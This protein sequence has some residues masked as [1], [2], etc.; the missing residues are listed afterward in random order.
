[1]LEVVAHELVNQKIFFFNFFF[2][3]VCVC[4]AGFGLFST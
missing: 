3:Y 2:F 1:M 4:D